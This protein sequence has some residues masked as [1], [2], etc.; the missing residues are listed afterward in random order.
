MAHGM[1]ITWEIF[2]IMQQIDNCSSGIRMQATRPPSTYIP[3]LEAQNHP[4][5]FTVKVTLFCNCHFQEFI[6]HHLFLLSQSWS[7]KRRLKTNDLHHTQ[8][9]W[10]CMLSESETKKSSS[11]DSEWSIS[12]NS[13]LCACL[14]I[15]WPSSLSSH[16]QVSRIVVLHTVDRPGDDPRKECEEYGNARGS[17]VRYYPT[18]NILPSKK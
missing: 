11:W 1:L 5:N 9:T 6:P 17:N 13:H 14:P 12:G 16:G 18:W 7:A 2:Q 3:P 10:F 4:L 15:L 8:G